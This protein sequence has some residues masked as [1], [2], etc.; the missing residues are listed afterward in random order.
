M[1]LQL[2]GVSRD[3]LGKKV[4]N[5]RDKGLIP[6]VVY[7][8]TTKPQ[9]IAIKRADLEKAY[10][11]VGSNTIVRVSVDGDKKT[12]NVLIYDVSEDPM[13]GF[14]NHVD[15]YCFKEGQKLSTSIP[16]HFIGE[17][18][19]IKVFG[20][21]LMKQIDE[22]EVRC[23]PEELIAFLEV[24][25]SKIEK[26]DDMIRI[27]DIKLPSTFEC[28]HEPDEIIALTVLPEVEEVVEEVE[29]VAEMPEVIKKGKD[30]EEAE[31]EEKK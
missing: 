15:F 5:L 10:K 18:K 12:Y 2:S 28:E 6:C 19:T 16:L 9:P 30:D 4:K 31:S 27:S 17:P 20:A 25:L 22:I 13:T 23:L 8:P 7:G 11:D 29:A 21:T 3:V 1:V 14:L 26:L 24:D